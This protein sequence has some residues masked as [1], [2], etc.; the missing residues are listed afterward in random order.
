MA[1][2]LGVLSALIENQVWFLAL[3]LARSL[4][5]VPPASG[6]Q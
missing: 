3:A 2:W 1:K 6:I 5:L 4:V